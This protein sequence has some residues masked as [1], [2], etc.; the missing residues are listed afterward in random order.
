MLG[1]PVDG[2]SG[3]LLDNL[4]AAAPTLGEN[5]LLCIDGPA[6][7]G[8]T[9]LAAHLAQQLDERSVVVAV[10]HCDDFYAGWSG[11]DGLGDP[12]GLDVR[13]Q[14]ELL[15]PLAAGR[16][17]RYRRWDWAR[18]R[19]AGW[20]EVPVAEVVVI[21]GVGAGNALGAP[22]CTALVWVDALEPLRH[23]R[24]LTRAADGFAAHWDAWAASETAYFARDRPSERATVRYGSEPTG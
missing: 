10:V 20:V 11:L 1:D 9:T 5:R 7:S 21:E 12:A 17:G 16:A 8:K 23:Q 2:R 6:G 3:G 13:L 18:S 15:E 24:A 22:F 14:D 4:M 19:W